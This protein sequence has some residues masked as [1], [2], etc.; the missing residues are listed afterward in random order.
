[1][2][3]HW[4][5]LKVLWSFH[6]ENECTNGGSQE[7]RLAALFSSREDASGGHQSRRSLAGM[8]EELIALVVRQSVDPH[9]VANDSFNG[10]PQATATA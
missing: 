9:A 8:A 7:D 10:N 3:S 2:G 5:T 1:M 4:R 6:T